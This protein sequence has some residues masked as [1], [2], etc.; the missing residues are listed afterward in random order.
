L[1]ED[2]VSFREFK[3]SQ[4]NLQLIL[5]FILSLDMK[6]NGAVPEELKEKIRGD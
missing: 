6:L 1:A 2:L 3:P 5:Q 4:K